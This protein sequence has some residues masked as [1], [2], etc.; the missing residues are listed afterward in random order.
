MTKTLQYRILDCAEDLQTTGIVRE[1]HVDRVLDEAVETGDKEVADLATAFM[2]D[3]ITAQE[4]VDQTLEL[5]PEDR[6][7]A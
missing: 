7:S 6:V 3:D 1:Y 5:V 4:F 2:Y